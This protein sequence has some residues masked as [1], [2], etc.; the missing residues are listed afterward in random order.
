MT[1]RTSKIITALT[2]ISMALSS[3]SVFSAAAS[4]QKNADVTP[5]KAVIQKFDNAQSVKSFTNQSEYMDIEM[6]KTYGDSLYSV[7]WEYS[8]ESDAAKRTQSLNTSDK[9]INWA[10]YDHFMIR[11]YAETAGVVVSVMPTRNDVNFV[12]AQDYYRWIFTTEDAGWHETVIPLSSFYATSRDENNK[13][14]WDAVKGVY[15]AT[16][17]GGDTSCAGA[18][19][20][21]IDE[22]WLEKRDAKTTDGINSTDYVVLNAV[23]ENDL[24][25]KN[26]KPT[27]NGATKDGTALKC[28][29][30]REGGNLWYTSIDVKAN[31]ESSYYLYNA[32]S[33]NNV[34]FSG[35]KYL[36]LWIYSPK[37]RN[38]EVKVGFSS[39][40]G[41]KQDGTT[42]AE[43]GDKN[44]MV[45]LGTLSWEGWKLVTVDMPTD[46]TPASGGYMF[47]PA[48]V[49][50]IWLNVNSNGMAKWA[51][52]GYYGIEKMWL[53]A[54]KPTAPEATVPAAGV[55]VKLPADELLLANYSGADKIAASLGSSADVCNPFIQNPNTSNN[56][57]FNSNIRSN[58]WGTNE[59]F[60]MSLYQAPE[61][62]GHKLLDIKTPGYQY[63][64]FW[65]YNPGVK[66]NNGAVS[67]ISCMIWSRKGNGAIGSIGDGASNNH[68]QKYNINMDWTGWKLV[69]IPLGDYPKTRGLHGIYLYVNNQNYLRTNEIKWS[70]PGNFVDVDMVW[71]S[72][73]IPAS[74]THSASIAKTETDVALNKGTVTFT[75][76][77]ELDSDAAGKISVLKNQELL[78]KDTDY[79]LAVEGKTVTVSFK[80]SKLAPKSQYNIVIDDKLKD[81]YGNCLSATGDNVVYTLNTLPEYKIS[82]LN[83]TYSDDKTKAKATVKVQVFDDIERSFILIAA[84]M[85]QGRFNAASLSESKLVKAEDG[86][87]VLNTEEIP[88][89][90]GDELS[91]MMWDSLSTIK[92]YMGREVYSVT[93]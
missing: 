18:G 44:A 28:D 24:P 33:V 92:P 62:N 75:F 11:Y 78:A 38:A 4:A 74:F 77:N 6:E 37:A 12:E 64:N 27:V 71:L 54:E 49:H 52:D 8:G 72:K 56:R 16:G 43:G 48:K 5:E 69:S 10:N 90:A 70:E 26:M 61:V 9:G 67:Q 68:Y 51:E 89:K 40:S 13:L 57:L 80:D 59:G 79:T 91:V 30:R 65:M 81:V 36:N 93:E 88:V 23:N 76:T 63:V 66:M 25:P 85:Y 39:R 58:A 31:T 2:T 20:I 45:S 87:V 46:Q 32:A 42:A 47:N 35:Y 34:N 82:G 84:D 41:K 1:K 83:I 53:S 21:Y 73:E 50:R 86:E 22:M 17:F 3:V 55:D 14:T 15:L 60:V 7:K 19:S 29:N